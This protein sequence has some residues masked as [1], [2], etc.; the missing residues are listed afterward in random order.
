MC[1]KPYKV[2]PVHIKKFAEHWTRAF[3]DGIY[4]IG[5]AEMTILAPVNIVF[6]HTEKHYVTWAFSP[7]S[8]SW[9]RLLFW[10]L[11]SPPV[12]PAYVRELPSWFLS[13]TTSFFLRKTPPLSTGGD[14]ASV[15][16]PASCILELGPGLQL[17]GRWF[18]CLP[19]QQ[20]PGDEWPLEP[21]AGMSVED[22]RVLTQSEEW[23]LQSLLGP[24]LGFFL[25]NHI[26]QKNTPQKLLKAVS[27]NICLKKCPP[28]PH[29]LHLQGS[30]LT[31]RIVFLAVLPGSW[32]HHKAIL[33]FNGC[34]VHCTSF[35]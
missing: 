10:Q 35:H 29:L 6:Y 12:H 21:T 33:T 1:N 4:I 5:G 19:A 14:F 32:G 7:S 31:F 23:K 13:K 15:F 26:S 28:T 30:Q 17:G 9:M 22:P 27:I 2:I 25:T 24:L 3:S 20:V 34:L 16:L 18:H 8:F 11:F